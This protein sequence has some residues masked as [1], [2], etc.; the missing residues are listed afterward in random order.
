MSKVLGK[1]TYSAY[2][3]DNIVHVIAEGEKPYLQTKVTIEQ[4]PFMIYPPIYALY[5]ETSGIT[6]P[7][8]VP[9]VIERAITNFPSSAKSI[10]IEDATGHHSIPIDTR[11]SASTGAHALALSEAAAAGNVCVFRQLGTERLLI[12]ACDAIL[13]AIY[14]RVFGP[15]SYAECQQ[16]VATHALRPVFDVRKESFK[17]WIDFM[18]GGPPKLIVIGEVTTGPA[19][20][21][22]LIKAVP[23]GINP[24]ILILDIVLTPGTGRVSTP[25]PQPVRYEESPPANTYTDVTIRSGADSFTIPVGQTH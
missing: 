12:A 15:A 4:L 24:N 1:A 2:R 16:Y 5:F 11:A 18:P 22:Q 9:F 20:G 23:Q 7:V 14:T 19:I 8:I 17:A 6:I 25:V 3:Q 13:P 21:V 10:S